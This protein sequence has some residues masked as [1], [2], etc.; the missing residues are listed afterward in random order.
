MV[1]VEGAS[2]SSSILGEWYLVSGWPAVIFGGWFYGRLASAV[3]ALI[4]GA[5]SASLNS[6]VYSISVMVLVAGLRSMQDLVVMSYAVL[7]WYAVTWLI[8]RRAIPFER[9]D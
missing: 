3:N 5:R 6:V 9:R 4:E 1:G 8:P 7:A 2:L